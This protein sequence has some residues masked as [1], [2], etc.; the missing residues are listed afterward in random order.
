MNFMH[1]KHK[2]ITGLLVI[3]LAVSIVGFKGLQSYHEEK[4]TYL[5]GKNVVYKA[6]DVL[7]INSE[8]F[9][10]T[11]DFSKQKTQGSPLIFGGAHYAKLDHQSAWDQ[12]AAVGITSMRSDFF[13]DRFLPYK[14]TLADYINN[15]NGVQ[16]PANWNQVEIGKIR[17][18]YKEARKRDMKTIGILTYAIKWLTY[19]NSNYGVPKD[20]N[21]YEDLVKKSYTLFRD[22]I[23]YLEIWNEPDLDYFLDVKNSGMAKDEAYYQIVKHAV[24]AIREVDGSKNDGRKMKIGVGVTAM[25][26]STYILQKVLSDKELINQVN[27]V[28]YHNYEHIPEPSVNQVKALMTKNGVGQLPIFLTEWAHSPNLKKPDPLV[29]SD[30][31]IPYAGGKL[32]DF[33]N[34]GLEGANYFALQPI[35][36]YSPRGDEGY[37]GFYEQKGSQTQLLPIARTWALMSK[38]LGL[39]KG[40]SI[41]Y[42]SN[43]DGIKKIAAWKNSDNQYGLVVTNQANT[44]QIYNLT[45]YNL[46]ISG[47]ITVNSF[48]AS[49]DE[50]GTKQIGSVVIQ[51]DTKS[52]TVKIV[53]PA[54]S[55]VGVKL[56][57]ASFVEMIPYLR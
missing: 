13:L 2:K 41:V 11:V 43:P 28:S 23:D 52:M 39:G 55:V 31:A 50:D 4:S 22:D 6:G 25:P 21:V 12:E 40:K 35:D 7:G 57:P 51:N 38:T 1:S 47:K 54:N 37:L 9:A 30:L 56:N 5:S 42:Q 17:N 29:L 53:A 24:K 27:F 33:M 8:E 26:T 10:A 32:I 14:T 48:V 15:V 36:P 49:G 20:W 44:S 45:L 46:P 3:L 18:A 16:D 19:S 34:M